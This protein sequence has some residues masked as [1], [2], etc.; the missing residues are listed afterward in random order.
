M[1][2][3]Q[4]VA[5]PQGL[6]SCVSWDVI[7]CA[8]ARAMLAAQ[9]DFEEAIEEHLRILESKWVCGIDG[10]QRCGREGAEDALGAGD[11]FATEG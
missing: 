4:G 8:S 11:D 1:D 6:P 5:V 7:R 3:W 10:N 9:G 2:A